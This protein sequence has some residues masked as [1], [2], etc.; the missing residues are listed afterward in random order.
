M[1]KKLLLALF[2][3]MLTT[4]CAITTKRKE[5][6]VVADERLT[7]VYNAAKKG[8]PKDN[9]GSIADLKKIIQEF[10]NSELAVPSAMLL[11]DYYFEKN[12]LKE[13]LEYYQFV[14]E[15]D[16]YTHREIEAV[17]KAINIYNLGSDKKSA[18]DLVDRVL[19]NSDMPA[20]NRKIYLGIKYDLSEEL[21]SSMDQLKLLAN[22]H[23]I[24]E[25][26]ADKTNVVLKA[27]NIVEGKIKPEDLDDII[28]DRSLSFIHA[29][30][31]FRLAVIAFDN[32]DFAN[33]RFYLNRVISLQPDSDIAE[34]SQDMLTQISSREIVNPKTIG[35]ILP[36]SGKYESMGKSVL[37]SIEYA[38][39]LYNGKSS[40]FKLA[41]VDS[42][43]KASVAQRGV[44]KLVI[45]DNVIA[46]VGSVL[47]KEAAAVA[48]KSQ[49]LGVPT[50]VLSQKA[51][52]TETG[53][54]I[55]RNALTGKMQVQYLVKNAMEKNGV[56]RFAILYPNDA[57]GIEYANLFWDEVI[58]N[59]GQV[60]AA[61]SY[62]SSETD[63]R[64]PV[65]RLVGTYYV[66]DREAEYGLHL[67][68]WYLKQPNRGS[69]RKK[70]PEDILPPI[71]DFEALFIPD[72]AKS[73]G[74]ISAMLA[75]NDV[76]DVMFL[77]T[78][79][80]NTPTI[81]NRVGKFMKSSL[82][83]DSLFQEDARFKDSSFVKNFT[84]VFGRAPSVFDIQAYDS[85]MLLKT[86]LKSGVETRRGVQQRLSESREISGA[87]GEISVLPNR[88]VTRPIVPLTLSAD[89]QI[90]RV[91]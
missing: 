60:T 56:N 38:L 53:E 91:Q 22:L 27:M 86:I 25:S 83:V 24:S 62:S 1:I 79:L 9:P 17:N 44:E 12:K 26:P 46:V 74:Q 58:A 40:P 65:Q 32:S 41:I 39:D 35:I 31:A 47:S 8:L 4:H 42:E 88:E 64:K 20:Q 49:S 90:I 19:K 70:I 21:L 80:W 16:F 63:F 57:Y 18:L 54:F 7:R 76:T 50:V 77:G 14:I 73:L 29:P 82:F 3:L 43:G 33:A 78:N 85:A 81:A 84:R 36:L 28:D 2:C 48:S 45:E 89:G 15:N 37:Y 67:K 59:G 34:R 52:I 68:E 69:S 87:L 30:I 71:V 6:P 13:A 10:S 72:S 75:Y 11:A 55:F 66:D 61:Q 51:D 23:E 5:K